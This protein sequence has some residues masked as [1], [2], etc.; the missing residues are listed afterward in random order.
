LG[1]EVKVVLGVAINVNFR[2][3][4]ESEWSVELVHSSEGI[5]QGDHHSRSIAW[6]GHASM[7]CFRSIDPVRMECSKM[8]RGMSGTRLVAL[9]QKSM[10]EEEVDNQPSKRMMGVLVQAKAIEYVTVVG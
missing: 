7:V 4:I 6:E 8:M 10:I 3:I 5:V 1:W 9:E 2:D